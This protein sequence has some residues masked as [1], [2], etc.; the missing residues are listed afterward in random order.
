MQRAAQRL[1]LQREEEDLQI[2]KM[3]DQIDPSLG[4]FTRY[5]LLVVT[6]VMGSIADVK[7]ILSFPH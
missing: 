5:E 3:L 6:G 4:S 7:F 1:Q 2:R